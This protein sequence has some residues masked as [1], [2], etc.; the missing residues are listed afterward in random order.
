[1]IEIVPGL[2][3][4][5]LSES[6]NSRLLNTLGISGILCCGE[7]IFNK[8]HSLYEY[9][10]LAVKNKRQHQWIFP[11]F[12]KAASVI[13]EFLK[14]GKKIVV[15]CD[16]T[17]H[18]SSALVSAFLIKYRGMTVSETAKAL[19]TKIKSNFVKQL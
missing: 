3:H 10:Q 16:N 14:N 8:N 19:R 13:N 11:F 4:A 17:K 9:T 7:E 2:F 18:R 5:T 1:M 6:E 12:D 15:H